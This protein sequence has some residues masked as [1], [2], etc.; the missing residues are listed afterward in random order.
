MA[1]R[2]CEDDAGVMMSGKHILLVAAAILLLTWV[3]AG[4]VNASEAL[5]G[6]TPTNFGVVATLVAGAAW[7][8]VGWL[9]GRG[10]VLGFVRLFVPAAPMYGLA[11]ALP[12]WEPVVQLIVPGAAAYLVTLAAPHVERGVGDS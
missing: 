6:G 11:L 1:A 10:S 9:A 5:K 2:T 8:M 7:P 3:V 4:V 12:S